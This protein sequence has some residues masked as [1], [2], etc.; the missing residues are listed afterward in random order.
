M[1]LSLLDLHFARKA[2]PDAELWLAHAAF[3]AAHVKTEPRRLVGLCGI[4]LQ[5][6]RAD[7]VEPP[8]DYHH[9]CSGCSRHVA[10]VLDR[11]DQLAREQIVHAE[12]CNRSRYCEGQCTAAPAASKP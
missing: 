4:Y 3:R 1:T 6:D 2:Y 5:K 8:D 11:A 10:D 9:L 7:R 12:H